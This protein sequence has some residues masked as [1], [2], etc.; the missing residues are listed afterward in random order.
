MQIG[1]RGRVPE[2]AGGDQKP[3]IKFAWPNVANR[4][5]YTGNSYNN[6]NGGL[7]HETIY[8]LP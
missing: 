1:P 8:N 2:G 3:D 6:N 7:A 4:E 5:Y